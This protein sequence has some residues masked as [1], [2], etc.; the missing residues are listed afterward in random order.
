[1]DI[2]NKDLGPQLKKNNIFVVGTGEESYI[3]VFNIYWKIIIYLKI[4]RG[5]FS[6]YKYK[7]GKK[8]L[9]KCQKNVRPSRMMMISK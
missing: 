8:T 9:R 7:R 6:E 5:K 4:V 1:M 2:K 3:L